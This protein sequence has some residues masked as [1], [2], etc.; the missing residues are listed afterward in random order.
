M[1]CI[2]IY[3]VSFT[4]AVFTAL[5][6]V[7]NWPKENKFTPQDHSAFKVSFVFSSDW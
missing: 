3:S 6:L 2:T 4:T 5:Q 1:Y 7:L